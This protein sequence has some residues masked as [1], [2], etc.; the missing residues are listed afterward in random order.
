MRNYYQFAP[1]ESTFVKFSTI[2]REIING[3]HE[4]PV[5]L[6]LRMGQFIRDNL[7][8]SSGKIHHDGKIPTADENISP[9]TERLIV[10]RWLELLHPS[11]PA[12]VSKV[13]SNELHTKSLKDLYPQILEQVD[14][15]I[16]QVDEKARD[17]EVSMLYT[18]TSFKRSSS[19]FDRTRSNVQRPENPRFNTYKRE[20]NKSRFKNSTN[21]RKCDAC[22]AFGEPFIGHTMYNCPNI[23]AKDKSYVLKSC[24]LELDAE[25]TKPA[26]T[27]LS[28]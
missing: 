10:L 27:T 11:L 8:L 21:F 13:F 24:A 3:N 9:T 19:N 16:C 4:R 22:L 25:E 7:L 5:H 6:Y 26:K 28:K 15:L 14:D 20:F 2:K 12:H 23:A 18:D 1:S 17:N